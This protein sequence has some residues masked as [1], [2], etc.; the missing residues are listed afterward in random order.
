MRKPCQVAGP[1]QV[2]DLIEAIVICVTSSES[3]PTRTRAT[4]GKAAYAQAVSVLDRTV[5]KGIIKKETANRHK[6]RL[7]LFTAKLPA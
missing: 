7:A 6:A 5:A 4:A 3:P 1:P 2:L